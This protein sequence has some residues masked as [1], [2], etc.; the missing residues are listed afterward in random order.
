MSE[1]TKI[2]K[3]F[4]GK[5]FHDFYYEDTQKAGYYIKKNIEQTTLYGIYLD[6]VLQTDNNELKQIINKLTNNVYNL[7]I[8]DKKG[9]IDLI[10]THIYFSHRDP[11]RKVS[12]FY[13]GIIKILKDAGY[14]NDRFEC[15]NIDNP[16]WISFLI[17]PKENDVEPFTL[18]IYPTDLTAYYING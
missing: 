17:T 3:V 13:D 4:N 14:I 8:T 12:T 5:T 1:E 10:E 7:I 15:D 16:T 2:L 18:Y 6:Y 11:S 9:K